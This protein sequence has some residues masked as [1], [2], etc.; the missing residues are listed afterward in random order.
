MS[1]TKR[2][3]RLYIIEY[4]RL[5]NKSP[6]GVRFGRVPATIL[7]LKMQAALDGVRGLNT[8]KCAGKR[9]NER[10]LAEAS[11]P[12]AARCAA[13]TANRIISARLSYPSRG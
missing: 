7:A 6:R 13:M 2:T 9:K 10:K 1:P 8:E 3:T 11:Y 5:F 12:R 4:R